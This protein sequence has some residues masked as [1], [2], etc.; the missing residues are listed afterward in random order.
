MKILYTQVMRCLSC[1]NLSFYAICKTCQR[2]LLEPTFNKRELEKD[3]FVYSFYPYEDIK[4]FI[5][6]KYEFYGDRVYNILAKLAFKKFSLNFRLGENI[7]VIPIDDHTRHEFSQTAILAK[8]LKSKHFK[9][10][11]NTLKAE[12]K[13]KYAGRDLEFRKKNPRRFKYIGKKNLKVVLVDDLV[14]TGSTIL[15]AKTVLE[16]NGCEVLFSLTLSD[17]KF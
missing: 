15:E 1:G 12:N 5:N 11:Y 14:T 17:A 13:V 3:F 6:T 10:L 8:H 7:I 16:A 2:N 9:V 4:E